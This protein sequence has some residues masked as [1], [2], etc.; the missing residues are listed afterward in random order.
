MIFLLLSIIQLL[1]GGSFVMDLA[2]ITDMVATRINKPLTWWRSHLS[3][4]V[5]RSLVIL[6]PWSLI[7]YTIL[8]IMMLGIT[9]LG[10]NHENLLN[11]L[12]VT[13]AIMFLPLILMI[14]GGFAYDIQR[15]TKFN[16]V[17]TSKMN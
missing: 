4:K 3:V 8:S 1:V 16:Q 15:Q 14:I 9:I 10:K 2:I 7:S 6:W 12:E 17:L 13:A 5:Q 11:L